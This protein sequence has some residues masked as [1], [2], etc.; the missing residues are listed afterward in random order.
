MRPPDRVSPTCQLYSFRLCRL[1]RTIFTISD[2][3]SPTLRACGNHQLVRC[4]EE[5][6]HGGLA[7][8]ACSCSCARGPCIM[9]NECPPLP[10]PAALRIQMRRLV[11]SSAAEWATV[12]GLSD[13]ADTHVVYAVREI[14]IMRLARREAHCDGEEPAST[15][16]PAGDPPNSLCLKRDG[17]VGLMCHFMPH[18]G[19]YLSDHHS[20]P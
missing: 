5:P 1:L 12:L 2:A 9:R 8:Q 13:V 18:S 4:P 3:A 15:E 14:P 11:A 16:R 7:S 17:C 19:F 6:L 10:C 20:T